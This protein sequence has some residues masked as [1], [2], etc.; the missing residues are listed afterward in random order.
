MIVICRYGIYMYVGNCCS[1]FVYLYM[2]NEL[3]I[4][5]FEISINDDLFFILVYVLYVNILN[6]YYCIV[7]RY[8][9]KYKY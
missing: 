2:I 1:L 8:I 5:F 4:L 9:L 3:F 6:Y 7:C